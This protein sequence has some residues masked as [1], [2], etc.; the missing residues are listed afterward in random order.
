MDTPRLETEVFEMP[1]FRVP[2][3][4]EFRRQMVELV[5]SGRTPEDLAREFEPTAQSIAHWVR[6]AE[7]DAGQR[8]DG[9]TTSAEREELSKLRRENHR[10][11]QE[12]DILA[13]AAAWFAKDKTPSGSSNS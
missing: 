10:L 1:R 13:K 2:Y 5:R 4:P 9:G 8:R 6:Q 3:P 12:R 7:R 11:R